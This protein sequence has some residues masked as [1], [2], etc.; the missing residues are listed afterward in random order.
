MA[1]KILIVIPNRSKFVTAWCYENAF[2]L[3]SEGNRVAILDLAKYDLRY[4]G[5]NLYWF[6]D[7]NLIEKNDI[8]KTVVNDLKKVGVVFLKPNKIL[9]DLNATTLKDS[10]V[11]YFNAM[12]RS[13]YAWHYGSSK[14]EHYLLNQKLLDRERRNF[15]FILNN[16]RSFLRNEVY[17]HIFTINGRT[18][19]DSCVVR[20]AQELNIQY[21]LIEK[22]SYNW[23]YYS[24]HKKA[25]QDIDELEEKILMNYKLMQKNQSQFELDA[26]AE[27]YFSAGLGDFSENPWEQLHKHK[28]AAHL[29]YSEHAVFYTGS[30]YEFAIEDS[31][32]NGKITFEDKTNFFQQANNSLNQ[33]NAFK[34]VMDE[35]RNLQMKLLVRIHPHPKGSHL[36]ET[37]GKLWEKV[38]REN[39]VDFISSENETDSIEIAKQAKVN[40]VFRSS[41]AIKIIYLKLPCIILGKTEFNSLV[42]K[43]CVSSKDGLV[44]LLRKPQIVNPNS[45]IPWAL[46]MAFGEIKIKY[47]EFYSEQKILYGGIEMNTKTK[48]GTILSK[49]IFR[50]KPKNSLFKQ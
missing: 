15:A 5:N 26:M 16:L 21:S 7:N 33:V 11:S 50:F 22:T 4:F 45:I 44:N 34:T 46:Y 23:K 2:R 35:C 20:C 48:F 14:F 9:T 6:Y 19:I 47:F 28:L 24:V 17:D 29:D 39:G 18:Q 10:D 36:H 32:A 30:D 31:I 38:C 12:I 43:L 41:I 37:D 3:I 40:I 13:A 27:E 8:R 42:P 49:F 1:P 25:P